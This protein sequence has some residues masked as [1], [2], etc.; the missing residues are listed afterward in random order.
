MPQLHNERIEYQN[1]DFAVHRL[2]EDCPAHT[3]IRELLKNAEESAIQ[4]TPPGRIEWFEEDVGGVRKLGLFNEGPGMSG[5]DLSRLMDMASTGKTLGTDDNF[6]QGGKVSA[7]RVSPAGVIYRSCHGGEVNQIVLAA[8]RRPGV[9]HP[10]YVKLR[11][12]VE[13]DGRSWHDAVTDVTHLYEGRKERPLDRDWTEVVLLGQ[14]SNQDTVAGLLPG[15][16][17][18]N[19]LVRETNQRF[20]RFPQGVVIRNADASSGQKE[21][22]LAQ[23]LEKLTL[24]WSQGDDGHHEDVQATHAV[25]GQ[26]TIR[27]FKLRGTVG[28]QSGNSRARTM[29]AYGVGSRG[30]HIC[31]VWKNECYEVVTGWSR[32]SGPFGVTFG[33]TNV[34]IQIVMPD[35][36]PV[37]NNAYR[38]RLLRRDD[39][40]Q[41]AI[42]EFADLVFQTRPRWL[43]EYV[44]EQRNRNSSG[45]NVDAR[46]QQF[47]REMMVAGGARS[48][49]EPG[50]DDQGERAGGG[51]GG[52]GG[53][54]GTNER[55]TPTNHT[56]ARG[57]R[58]DQASNG[59]PQ[60]EFTRD[61]GH[62]GQMRDRAA[63][64]SAHDNLVLLNPDHFRYQQLLEAMYEKVGPDAEKRQV[65]LE[66]FNE[67]YRVQAGRF[68]IQAWIFRGRAE[69]DD[70]QIQ[71]ALSMGSLTLMLASP[72]SLS[73]AQARYNRRMM[74]NRVA[75]AG[76]N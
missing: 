45:G 32:I 49:V 23:G 3:V 63:M 30:D 41:V 75:A 34:A 21:T 72:L 8:E 55:T 17:H 27:Y 36:A 67:E 76:A 15:H 29:Q 50:G 25:Y 33:S 73:E 12:L 58:I 39:A 26:V 38:D 64:Y 60:V 10:I 53:G 24:N 4:L 9:S 69:W 65:A 44:E 47:L 16:G 19:W 7:L 59:I 28:E 2:V 11:T 43:I 71:E 6:G 42:E 70:R 61:L 13:R 54:S 1:V 18:T 62:L 37:R 51:G 5:G 52:G 57:R 35:D 74:T 14:Q 66:I 40:H 22:R 46:L 48:A 56:P 31:L 68:V 20:Y